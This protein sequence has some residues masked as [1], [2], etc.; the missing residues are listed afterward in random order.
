[1]TALAPTAIAGFS[2]I[3]A[4]LGFVVGLFLNVGSR[5]VPYRIIELAT[6]VAFAGVTA[7]TLAT[8]TAPLAATAAVLVAYLYFLSIAVALTLIDLET[9]R[10]PNAI[11]LPSYLVAGG[12]FAFACVL[13]ADGASL[14]RAAIGGVVL[15]AFYGALRLIGPGAMGGGDVK[16][17]GVIGMYLGWLGWGALAVGA[18]AAF[19]LGGAF[20]LA[21]LG[22]R[23]AGRRTAIP[24]GPWMLLGALAGIVVGE[25]LGGWYAGFVVPT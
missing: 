4:A 8:A 14:V 17:A 20:G 6:S 11:V 21:L 23:R 19:F 3:A 7:T 15:F 9:H 12:L 22:L 5:R 24:F 2:A 13:G 18:F 10:L 25:R 16:L 1:M